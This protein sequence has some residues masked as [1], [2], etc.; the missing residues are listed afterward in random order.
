[1]EL[2]LCCKHGF[3]ETFATECNG[4]YQVSKIKRQKK[5]LIGGKDSIPLLEYY[6][7]SGIQ[8]SQFMYT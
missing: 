1:M 5:K 3:S 6:N 2:S 8:C 7:I 4:L